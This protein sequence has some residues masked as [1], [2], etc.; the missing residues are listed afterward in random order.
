M[1]LISR[2]VETDHQT[3]V[4]YMIYQ[5]NLC[6]ERYSIGTAASSLWFHEFYHTILGYDGTRIPITDFIMKH[7][8]LHEFEIEV[9]KAS[10]GIPY[11]WACV[12]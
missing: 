11:D 4:A 5:C 8:K 12:T 9:Y 3:D 6:N 2:T 7:L 10:K 1:I